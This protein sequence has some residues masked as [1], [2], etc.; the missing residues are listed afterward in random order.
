MV[1][2]DGATPVNWA[3]TEP[4]QIVWVALME[5]TTSAG[6]IVMVTVLVGNGPP[7][8]PVVFCICLK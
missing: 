8:V 3:G 5:P 6:F 7:H 1:P 2:F 4:A